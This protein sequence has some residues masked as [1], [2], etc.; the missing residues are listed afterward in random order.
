MKLLLV[1][2]IALLFVQGC[3]DSLPT[4]PPSSSSSSVSLSVAS[5][6]S[7]EVW[8]RLSFGDSTEQ[9]R[10]FRILRND[11]ILIRGTLFSK[12][13]LIADRAFSSPLFQDGTSIRPNRT[14]IFSAVRLNEQTGTITDSSARVTV[15]TL[16]TTSHDYTWTT[17]TL[18]EGNSFLMD[19]AIVNDTCV[20]AVGQMFFRDST[21]QV[22]Q[23]RPFC[24]AK[25]DGHSWMPLQFRFTV[26]TTTTV[27][28][29]FRGVFAFS[30]TDVWV[31]AGGVWRLNP[32]TGQMQSFSQLLRFSPDFILAPD[33]SIEKIWGTGPNNIYG[34][35]TKGIIVHYNGQQ[36]RVM[37]SGTTVDLRDIYGTPDG[38]EVW[39][40]GH[41]GFLSRSTIL[42]LENGQWVKIYET[43]TSLFPPRDFA[44]S[45]WTDSVRAVISC[46]GQMAWQS[47]IQEARDFPG[48]YLDDN[49]FN[50]RTRAVRGSAQNNLA[51]VGEPGSIW[52]WNGYNWRFYPQLQQEGD[53]YRR[54]AVSQ[55]TI[56]AVGLRYLEFPNTAGLITIGRKP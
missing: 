52:H 22:N 14:Y 46:S 48:A 49:L 36:W 50:M 35:G 34:V 27:A 7:N 40:V 20:Y 42:K 18:G 15:R 25:W 47:L 45:I 41:E 19:V 38:K 12:D 37:N 24:F 39:A 43:E 3:K 29:Q 17:T 10:D 32:L 51:V 56:A 9:P 8:L 53:L 31:A 1:S 4:K 55:T 28:P 2:L 13:T 21:G 16:D 23:E 5:V 54:V 26:G 30:P 11:S 6:L 33:Q 44:N